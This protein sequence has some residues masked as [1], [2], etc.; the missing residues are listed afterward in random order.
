MNDP[1]AL[2]QTILNEGAQNARVVNVCDLVFDSMFRNLC[3][4]N[5]CGRYGK[6]YTCP[7]DVGDI[8]TLMDKARGYD[9]G[10]L[11]QTIWPLEDSFDIEGMQVAGSQH[12]A[13]SQRIHG[14]LDKN[15]LHL[16]GGGCRLCDVCAKQENKPCRFPGQAI[17]SMS[18]YGLNVYEAAKLAGL[19]Y[20][21][22]A[23]TVTYF[24][25]VF[26]KDHPN[27]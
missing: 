16:S 26:M 8:D 2:V 15:M 12:S 5:S 7:P 27:A 22:G 19:K 20:V 3:V 25:I 4:A 1:E 6:C 9:R 23:N 17:A 14:Y 24:G 18:A 10:V 21:N 13:L 11:Y